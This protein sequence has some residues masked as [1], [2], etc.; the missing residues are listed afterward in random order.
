MQ[1][2][3]VRQRLASPPRLRCLSI[4]L[5]LALAVGLVEPAARADL[6]AAETTRRAVVV[7][8]VGT[9]KIMVGE[10]EDRLA[11]VPR[12]QLE[13]FGDSPAAIKRAF[14]DR[15]LIEEA[16]VEQY[17]ASRE[18]HKSAEV[19]LRLRRVASNSLMRRYEQQSTAP[20]AFTAAEVQR[21]YDEH[22]ERYEQPLRIQ[23]WRIL[24]ATEAE[25]RDVLAEA[26]KAGTP[27]KFTE[28]A[29]DKSLD[30]AS[31]LRGGNLGF[32]AENGAAQEPTVRVDPRLFLAAAK[33][34]DGEFVPEP[35][36][37]G[38]SFAVVWRR[39]STAGK[40]QA[41]TEVEPMIRQTLY[42]AALDSFTKAQ[43]DA[44]R[45]ARVRDVDTSR[46]AALTI[47]QGDPLFD[48]Q[49]TPV[50]AKPTATAHK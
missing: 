35:V 31:S 11:A 9:R 14:L 19:A 18:I 1:L 42:R 8:T 16:L 21:Y 15:V 10:F 27:A 12:F 33:V 46:F 22:R 28:L 37:E 7:A 23:L 41:L 38:D 40:K 25:A 50:P 48:P 20:A 3:L 49:R 32:L 43:L 26:R 13:L 2:P 29:R 4:A 34:A 30:K 24:V 39:G 6:S 17:A 45:T 44:L 36:P 5:L 47:D